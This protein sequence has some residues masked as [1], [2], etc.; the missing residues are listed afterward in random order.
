ME[1]NIMK[2][3]IANLIAAFV[4]NKETRRKIRCYFLYRKTDNNRIVIIKSDGTGKDVLFVSGLNTSFRGRNNYIEIHEPFTFKNSSICLTNNGRVIIGE[5]SRI[6]SL[7]IMDKWGSNRSNLVIGKN[8]FCN[9][10]PSKEV[11][12]QPSPKGEIIIGNDCVFSWGIYVKTSDDHLIYDKG[13][14]IPP[15]LPDKPI[16]VGDHC[17]ICKDATILKGAVIPKN[18]AVG[19]NAVVSK[20]FRL[21][22]CVIAGNPAK[23][24]KQN[25]DWKI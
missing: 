3:F 1:N 19:A 18:S 6:T 9:G 10:M 11:C 13:S 8:L 23:I 24:V 16:V 25:I 5:N 4:A 2:K 15:E 22:N 7:H 20:V 17:W 12:L 14:E 21:E